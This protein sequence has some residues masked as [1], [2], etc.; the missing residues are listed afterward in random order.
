MI[1]CGSMREDFI[2]AGATYHGG[3]IYSFPNT[4]A[5]RHLWN[6]EAVERLKQ[7]YDRLGVPEHLRRRK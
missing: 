1:R 6:V 3:G 7:L 4:D 2:A 5:I